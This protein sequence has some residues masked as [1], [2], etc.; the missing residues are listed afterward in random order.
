MKL[1]LKIILAFVLY[2]FLMVILTTINP[3]LWVD[4]FPHKS[5]KNVVI[6]AHRGAAG[7]AP[8]NTLSA[9]QKGIESGAQRIEVD[10]HQSKDGRLFIM[11][12]QSV[13]RTTNGHGLIKNLTSIQLRRLDAG[14]WYSS[15]FKGEKIP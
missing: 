3:A 8:E 7:Y 10:I 6:T 14:N 1:W 13:D 12:D 15:E 9:I 11:H 5:S 4:F 2:Y